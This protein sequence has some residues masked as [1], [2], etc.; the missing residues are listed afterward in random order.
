MATGKLNQRIQEQ[1]S[2]ISNINREMSELK[3]KNQEQQSK[4]VDL[5]H[6]GSWCA[7]QDKWSASSYVITYDEILHSDSNMDPHKTPFSDSNMNTLN[8]GNGEI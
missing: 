8:T 4:I 6:T 3:Q 2:V 5:S 7:F 1:K